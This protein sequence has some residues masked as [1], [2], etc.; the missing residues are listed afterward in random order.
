M[1]RIHLCFMC[2]SEADIQKPSKTHNH[3]DPTLLVTPTQW[4]NDTPPDVFAPVSSAMPS[5]RTSFFTVP[6]ASLSQK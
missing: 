3:P 1:M 5:S 4:H 2:P 6:I